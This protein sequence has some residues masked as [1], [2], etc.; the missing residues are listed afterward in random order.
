MIILRCSFRA[1]TKMRFVQYFRDF[2]RSSS[3]LETSFD[4]IPVIST[5][6]GPK[7]HI[8]SMTKGMK[9]C[10]YCGNHHAITFFCRHLFGHELFVRCIDL[11]MFETSHAFELDGMQGLIFAKSHVSRPSYG[12]GSYYASLLAHHIRDI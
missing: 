5:A 2:I 1:A 11:Q 12:V 8:T 10:H 3:E 9:P 7:R 6:D 4:G